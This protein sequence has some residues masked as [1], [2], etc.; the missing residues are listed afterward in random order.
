MIKTKEVRQEVS[1]I[2]EKLHNLYLLQLIDSKLDQLQVL[3]GELPMEV[4]DLEDEVAGLRLRIEKNQ[5]EAKKYEDAIAH[6]RNSIKDAEALIKKYQKQQN[7]V[8]NNREYEAL[9]KE[10]EL[11]RLEIQLHE[12]KIKEASEQLAQ[13]Q[14]L[15]QS[16]KKAIKEKEKHLALKQEE[17]QHILAETEEEE[18]VL[19]K[20][21]AEQSAKLEPR[22]LQAYQRI[23]KTY[24]NGLA[25]VTIKRDACGGCFNAIPPQTQLEVRQRKKIIICEH[26]GRILVD[27]GLDKK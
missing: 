4:K 7:N 15:E 6:R 20:K 8:K 1:N 23:R 26:C 27:E 18:K 10:I 24:R 16:I 13:L 11:Q 19:R 14:A 17:L 2:E 25:V 22:L 12:K 3:K 9:N 5:E 21:S